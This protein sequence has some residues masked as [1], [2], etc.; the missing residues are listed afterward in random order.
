M[1]QEKYKLVGPNVSTAKFCRTDRINIE[2]LRFI[3]ARD[4][5]NLD[6]SEPRNVSDVH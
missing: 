5:K 4:N 3:Q 6:G 1:S 2:S